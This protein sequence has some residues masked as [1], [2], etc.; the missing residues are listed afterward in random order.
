MEHAHLSELITNASVQKGSPGLNANQHRVLTVLVKM[1][2]NVKLL[3]HPI[4]AH[5][6]RASREKIVKSA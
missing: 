3:D 1:V 2:P 4:S 5:V 6:M